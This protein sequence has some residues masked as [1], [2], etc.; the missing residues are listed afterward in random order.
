MLYGRFGGFC[1]KYGDG[2][3]GMGVIP[4]W[5]PVY[6]TPEQ[7]RDGVF[8]FPFQ[9]NLVTMTRCMYLPGCLTLQ[10]PGQTSL[11]STQ[12]FLGWTR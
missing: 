7:V 4:D 11:P 10:P 5:T 1:E 3:P 12:R 2:S 9:I 6:Y 8:Y